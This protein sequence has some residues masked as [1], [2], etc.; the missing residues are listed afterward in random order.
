MK[1]INKI[2]IFIFVTFSCINSYTQEL[3]ALRLEV[4]ADIDLESYHVE[5]ISKKGVL[6][7]Y[8]SSEFTAEKKR[9]WYFGYFDTT[10][11]QKWLKFLPL[12]DKMQFLKSYK[13]DNK[14]HLLFRNTSG[15]RNEAGFYEILSFD[16]HKEVFEQISGTFPAKAEI[17]GFEV[18][19]STAC[20]G[21]NINKEGTDLLFVNLNSGEI[22][23]VHLA[24]S[25]PSY[26]ETVFAN[27]FD[28]NFYI[29]LKVKQ[30]NRYIK[31]LINTISPNG[32]TL[33]V[34]EIISDD[35]SKLLRKFTFC[36]KANELSVLGIYD[37]HKGRLNDFSKIE[38]ADNPKTA[39]LFF[40]NI[41]APN[42]L[43]VNF[44]DFVKLDNINGSIANKKTIK[45][46]NED[47]EN[48]QVVSSF[49][50]I[51]KPEVVSSKEG[52]L[53]TAEA[54]K[55]HY[56]TETRMDY[57]FYGRPYPYTYSVFAG[58]LFYDVIIVSLDNNG[59]LL[60][61]ND[62]ILRDLK[63]FSL[64][65]HSLVFEDGNNVTATY[66][67]D[68]K[69]FAST[70]DGNL[71]VS[72]DESDIASSNEKDRVVQDE[73][74]HIEKWYDDYFIIYGYQKI[75]NRSLSK[76][77]ERVIFYLNKVAYK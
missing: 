61:N 21:I 26:I 47:G 58:Y 32:K 3:N 49:F 16:S 43:K 20:L 24:E 48:E 51:T 52:F 63:S 59:N 4:P 74:N 53:F 7:F 46:K 6:I 34:K 30:D 77:D 41:N 40:V 44:I 38:D 12:E 33:E 28:N 72:S 76:K 8:E 71:D 5:P 39:G 42:D 56:V 75:K 9:K 15:G 65:R 11:Q 67:N 73:N 29:A 27:D 2:L 64:K 66:V 68:G 57:D 54:Y 60:W 45:I 69:I 37:Y 25:Y 23:P 31:D 18:I 35:N 62:F 19:G 50:N 22:N 10:L 17:A 70:F 14:L 36:A 13:V 1:H 55:P